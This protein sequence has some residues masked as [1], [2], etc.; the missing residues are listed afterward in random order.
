MSSTVRLEVNGES[1]EY[2]GDAA[3]ETVAQLIASLHLDAT[4]VVAEVNGD[5]VKRD[6]F[7]RH[8]LADGDKVEIVRFV[9][10]G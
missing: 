5:I 9:G 10:G 2:A 3:P 6:D 4:M 8:I 1:R 7:A